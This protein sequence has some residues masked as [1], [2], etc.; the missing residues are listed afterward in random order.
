MSFLKHFSIQ[1]AKHYC[2]SFQPR[3]GDAEQSLDEFSLAHFKGPRAIREGSTLFENFRACALRETERYIFLSASHFRRALDLMVPSAIHW[4]HVT[5]YYGAWY[6]AHGLLGMLGCSVLNTR[7][8]KVIYV[9]KSTPGNQELYVETIGKGKY[10]VTH[11]GSHQRFWEIFYKTVP[12]VRVLLNDPAISA[13]LTPVANNTN[14]LINQRNR[15]N[16][17]SKNGIDLSSAFKSTFAEDDFPNCLPGELN[18]QFRICEGL[19]RAS[20][21]FASQFGLTTDALDV[22]DSAQP[23]NQKILNVIY[24]SKLPNLLEKTAYKDIFNI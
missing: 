21:S 17:D 11:R 5:L 16:Y 14:W 19:I 10:Y 7:N 3:G 9:S 18:T 24:S 12:T 6:A 20:F 4:A 22:L 2:S 15:F 8:N 1:E 13:A 23:I